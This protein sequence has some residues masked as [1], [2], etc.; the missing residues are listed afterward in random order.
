MEKKLLS[1]YI[2][3][4]NRVDKVVHQVKFFIEEIAGDSSIELVVC[5]NASTDGT[6]IKLK[7]LNC[8]N[9]FKYYKNNKNLGINGN[10]YNVLKYTTG[11]YIWIV[12]DDD[13]LEHGVV[14][15]VKKILSAREKPNFVFLNYSICYGKNFY[16]NT[17]YKGENG[18]IV[19][20]WNKLKEDFRVY[21]TLMIFTTCIIHKRANVEKVMRLIPLDGNREYGWSFILGIIALKGGNGYF[22][23]KVW[24]WDQLKDIS[25]KN[26]V[27]L[28]RRGMIN[29]L[30][31]LKEFGFRK[32]EI[33][34][35]QRQFMINMDICEL[36][37]DELVRKGEYK[38]EAIDI[39]K[40]MLRLDVKYVWKQFIR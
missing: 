2:P 36:T 26:I 21:S 15:N 16:G 23:K 35:L 18:I 17:L 30:D 33:I 24:M 12:G 39:L 7:Q 32:K 38:K 5:D 22:D 19:D 14:K 20:T 8:D 40:L 1:I 11:N 9:V 13:Y 31:I 28:S 6:E 29:S 3:T 27:F 10:A 34:N 4:Y 37:I 25:W